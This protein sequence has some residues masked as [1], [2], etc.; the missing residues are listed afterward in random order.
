MGF[1]SYV[2]HFYLVALYLMHIFWHSRALTYIE[3]GGG[4]V[5]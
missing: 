2:R 4:A 5:F 1:R 3:R